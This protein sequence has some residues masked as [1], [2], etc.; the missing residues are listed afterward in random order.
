MT[1]GS[2]GQYYNNPVQQVQQVQPFSPNNGPSCTLAN[3]ILKLAQ[4]LQQQES[5]PVQSLPPQIYQPTQ[6]YPE[7]P[8]Q[9]CNTDQS[10]SNDQYQ[11]V[12]YRQYVPYVPLNSNYGGYGVPNY[13]SYPSSQGCYN[14]GSGYAINSVNS[15][16]Y[17]YPE[18]IMAYPN[19]DDSVASATAS[20][21]AVS[22][23]DSA[24]AVA[25][26]SVATQ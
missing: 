6:Y 23:D 25:T 1:V 17:I 13:V 19:T 2:Y 20:A 4:M 26:A 7:V 15:G 3:L 18:I 5:T 10:V 11:Y 8:A 16:S 12:T 14:P 24:L 22:G 9:S 21:S